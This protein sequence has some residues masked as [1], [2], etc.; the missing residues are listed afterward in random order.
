[1]LNVLR[2]NLGLPQQE[3]DIDA[4][5][6]PIMESSLMDLWNECDHK[7]QR[8]VADMLS[9]IT[10]DESPNLDTKPIPKIA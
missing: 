3:V 7:V 6:V 4:P 8:A 10:D 2:S 9:I 5:Q 1:M